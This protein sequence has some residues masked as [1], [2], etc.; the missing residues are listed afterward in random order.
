MFEELSWA[1]WSSTATPAATYLL[2]LAQEIMRSYSQITVFILTWILACISATAGDK[3][4]L[5]AVQIV[6]PGLQA[7]GI[8]TVGEKATVSEVI[9][10][11]KPTPFASRMRLVIIRI[12][13][14]YEYAG[15]HRI[16]GSDRRFIDVRIDP[17]MRFR[18]LPLKKGDILYVPE[19][20]PVRK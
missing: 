17:K 6:G 2:T 13:N 5:T 4:D 15:D 12:E 10:K 19:R 18:D 11:A 3:N 7:P 8:V 20:R 14:I 16:S 9:D 1:F